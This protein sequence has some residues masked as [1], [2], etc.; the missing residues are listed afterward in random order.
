MEE[1]EDLIMVEENP[2]NEPEKEREFKLKRNR[3][4]SRFSRNLK[5]FESMFFH[6]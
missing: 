2:S 3:D 5:T 6:L 4:A 1:R